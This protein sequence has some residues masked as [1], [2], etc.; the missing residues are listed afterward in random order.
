MVPLHRSL[1]AVIDRARVAPG[2]RRYVPVPYQKH[3]LTGAYKGS[4]VDQIIM[5]ILAARR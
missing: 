4:V 1:E 2:A 5:S 3:D